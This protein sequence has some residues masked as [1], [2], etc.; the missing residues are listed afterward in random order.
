MTHP[1]HQ[2]NGASLEDCHTNF[3]ALTDLCGIKW[4]KLLYTESTQYASTSSDPLEDPVL[5]SFSKCLA[6]DI[7]CV[8]RRVQMPQPQPSASMASANNPFM[9]DPM[10]AVAMGGGFHQMRQPVAPMMPQTANSQSADPNT[11]LSLHSSKELWIFWYG[12]EPDL[13][14][15]VAFDKLV[16]DN[17]QGSWESG[18]S[19]ECRSLLFKALHNLIERCLLSHD[20]VRLGKWFVQTYHDNEK[21][22]DKSDHLSIS[23]QFFVH[24][25]STVCVSVD[26]R[27][28]PPVRSLTRQHI[29]AAQAS[30]TGSQVILAPFGMSGIL[31]GQTFK[32]S[33]SYTRKLIEEWRQFYPINSKYLN[34]EPGDNLP[35]P[36]AVEVIV[37]GAKMRYPTCFVLATDMDDPNLNAA[38]SA[39]I[40]QG[41]QLSA[42][43]GA[44]IRGAAP[45]TPCCSVGAAVAEPQSQ[46]APLKPASLHS[47]PVLQLL[48]D[49]AIALT[50]PNKQPL[51]LAERVWQDDSLNHS[52]Q[53]PFS[54]QQ[55]PS[56]SDSLMGGEEPAGHWEF[57]DPSK[58]V[59]C[60]CSKCKKVNQ[61]NL[62]KSGGLSTSNSGLKL[63]GEKSEKNRG[64][65]SGCS[66]ITPYHHRNPNF[67]E[68]D[69]LAELEPTPATRVSEPTTPAGGPPSY[70][71]NQAMTPGMQQSGGDLPVPSVGSPPSAAPSPLHNPHSQ[72]AS[73]TAT[74]PT[75]P[76]LSPHPPSSNQPSGAQPTTPLES[77]DKVTPA[78]TPSDINGPKSVSSISNQVFS[79][80]PTNSSVE[81]SKP[82][83]SM[84]PASASSGHVPSMPTASSTLSSFLKRPILA[85]KDYESI[86]QDEDQPSDLLYDYSTMNAWLNHPVKRYKAAEKMQEKTARPFPENLT[87]T[88]QVGPANLE[89]GVLP[90]AVKQEPITGDDDKKGGVAPFNDD[91][92][93]TKTPSDLFTSR[94][95]EPSYKDL[96]QIFDNSDDTSSDETPQVPTPPGSNKAP[97]DEQTITLVKPPRGSGGGTGIL[98]VEELTK[99]Y[100]T[101]P[102]L[103]HNP[104]ASPCGQPDVSMLD[105]S[106]SAHVPRI[107]QEIYANLGSPTE[108][109][110]DDWSYVYKPVAMYKMV[111]SSKYAPLTNLPS[112]Q[113]SALIPTPKYKPAWQYPLQMQEKSNQPQNHMPPGPMI[114]GP[115]A[116]PHRPPSRPISGISPISPAAAMRSPMGPYGR[117][118]ASPIGMAPGVMHPHHRPALPP[119]YEL[120]SPASNA[121]YMNKSVSSVEPGPLSAA[122]IAARAPEANSLV[123]N[124]LLTD[125]SLHV[126]RDHNFDSC[127]MCVCNAGPKVVGNIRGA[128]LCLPEAGGG[129][130]SD[131]D[132][133]RCNCGF[134]AV[135]NRKLSHRAGLF[136]E[137]EIEI[138]GPL[139]VDECIDRK[140]PSLSAVSS[141]GKCRGNELEAPSASMNAAAKQI[142]PPT[143][144]SNSILEIVPQSVLELIRDQCVFVK[145]S[146]N[147]LVRT[148]F[149]H[150]KTSDSLLW[151][152]NKLEFSDGNDVTLM[153]LDQGRQSAD[154]LHLC[155]LN[156]D[157]MRI[158]GNSPLH[159]WQFL[160][161]GGP[162]CNQDIIRVM[163][164]LQPLLQEAVQQKC[165]T[166]LWDAPYTVSGPLTWRKFHR[167]AGRGTE[168]RCE[169][170]PIPSVL[171]G[172]DSDWVSLSPYAIQY[173]EN[174]L[175]EPYSYT[176]DVAYIVVAPDNEHV[177]GHVRSFFKELSAIY[178]LC[179]LGRH[180][181]I[182]KVLRDGIL[183][184]G[185]SS[186]SK[187]A[188]EPVDEWFSTLSESQTSCLLKLYAQV[189]RYHL[190]PH[191]NSIPMDKTLF[192]DASQP[193][194]SVEMPTPSPMP[195]PSTP[196]GASQG[197][198]SDRQPS[199]PKTDHG[200]GDG[201]HR[202]SI[203]GLQDIHPDDE[204]REPPAIVIYFVDPFSFGS[205][206]EDKDRLACLGLLRC[207]VEILNSVPEHIRANL[208][209][210][211]VSLESILELTK[212][213]KEKHIDTVRA[214]ALSV[215]LQCRRL[216]SHIS[217]VKSLT[218]FGPAANSDLFL[219]SKDEKNRA[220]YR[221]FT[222][223]YVLGQTKDKSESNSDRQQEKTSVMYCNYCLSED[224]RFLMAA[225][226]DDKGA[227]FE[228]V[229]INIEIPHRTR[230]KKASARRVGLQKL[231]DFILG[232]MSRT[233]QPWR[234]VVGR[235]GRIGHGELKGWSWLLS[236]KSLV[237][238]SKHLKEICNQCSLQSQTDIPCILSACLVSMEPDSSLRLMPDQ[239]TPDE[240]FSQ[241]SVK[242]SLSTPQD[243]SAT[244]ILVFPTSATTQSSQS[245]FQEQH[246]ND[247]EL[248]DEELFSALND[249]NVMDGIDGDF[250]DIFSAWP[251]PGQG[252]QSPTGSPKRDS[253][254]QPGSPGVMGGPGQQSPYPCNTNSMSSGGLAMEVQEEVGTLL[255]QPLALGYFVSTAKTG[256]MPRWFW[257]SCPHL[258][259]ANPT[260]LKNALHLHSTSIQN[261]DD[262]LQQQAPVSEHPLDS[263]YTTDVLRYVMEGYNALSWLALDHTAKDRLSCLPVH[264]QVL[265]QLYHMFSA[266]V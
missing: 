178:E 108:E 235:V 5:S 246:I 206:E 183:R 191:L 46:E 200:D 83:D 117:M 172:R 17:E 32:T 150:C 80:Y 4:R 112:Q 229:C 39:P 15:L 194:T 239:F 188:K 122:V 31:T 77:Q 79:P 238:A 237:K 151:T 118:E 249:D 202:D 58:K 144:P 170:Q 185:K 129:I 174:L 106:E 207:Y 9:M 44:I 260:F 33:D 105:A 78:A 228:T 47:S 209:V 243:V 159:R 210:Q 109:N 49:P 189:C 181:P 146:V 91:P 121:P 62:H 11:T 26:V 13:S 142:P 164:N 179:R 169:P 101:P 18:L 53:S 12:E 111:G 8:W 244:H 166:R 241:A 162:N 176:R 72:P 63:K 153:A 96:D 55:Q 143:E 149:R 74:D 48:A 255:Q 36:L 128:D 28:H 137:D 208:N 184:V 171:V 88:T 34:R 27:Q 155:K 139:F 98:K 61:S 3:F 199:T 95:L 37:S 219:K 54:S 1:N 70:R 156:S 35:L 147:T 86:M 259:D 125:S 218:G 182:T 92:D 59:S 123:V 93:N 213:K 51:N 102:S 90:V 76:T 65:R 103:E 214:Q 152:L 64:W 20:F 232:I 252:A 100:P 242:C 161:A 67:G 69:W 190:T 120:A 60:S 216:M 23:F 154:A 119:P 113:L 52:Q 261:S 148:A 263:I 56:D 256:K 240:R 25:E 107:K 205:E 57:Q 81:P 16:S 50:N 135:V 116:A 254:S 2:T 187:I 160:R 231:M 73:V 251:E 230:R 99:M 157:D 45:D 97:G 82:A 127:T 115:I 10:Q 192:N 211:I 223:P 71:V 29:L 201:H 204:E 158:R 264:V 41:V 141:A 7:L 133:I 134:S 193:K 221:L 138:T 19:Y 38:A 130:S 180:C 145:S 233:V 266:L 136:Y 234:L 248:G 94:G 167:L 197:S 132:Q 110:I 68:N 104:I 124:I 131:E 163:R 198:S 66:S 225:C 258:E 245:A 250:G 85:S 22:S 224:Q 227:I 217:N 114:P 253:M 173:W 226:T 43:G 196:E 177:L 75:M 175:L 84:G 203:G 6:A 262:L 220:P 222:P 24:G 195:P 21:I 126:F 215:Y 30:A 212:G 42:V 247:P 168:D 186:D 40:L 257:A 14:N 236:R 140:R 165:T 87:P 89:V 265:M